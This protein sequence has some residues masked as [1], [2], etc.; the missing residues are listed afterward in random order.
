MVNIIIYN[1]HKQK[2]FG[3]LSNSEC[4]NIMRSKRLKNAEK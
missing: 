2:F 4:E 1:P 3:N